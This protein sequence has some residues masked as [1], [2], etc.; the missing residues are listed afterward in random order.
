MDARNLLSVLQTIAEVEDVDQVRLTRRQQNYS[1]FLDLYQRVGYAPEETQARLVW[2]KRTAKTWRI[3]DEGVLPGTCAGGLGPDG[4]IVSGWGTLPISPSVVYGH[5]VC[6]ERTLWGVCT[7]YLLGLYSID[8]A[9]RI[10]GISHWAGSYPNHSGFTG[11]FQRPHFDIPGQIMVDVVKC[12]PR[13]SEVEGPGTE[14]PEPFQETDLDTLSETHRGVFHLL[15]STHPMMAKVHKG[16]TFTVRSKCGKVDAVLLVFDAIPELTAANVLSRV[17]AFP[18]THVVDI[19]GLAKLLQNSSM[20]HH[21]VL[22]LVM[23]NG[24]KSNSL[25]SATLIPSFW[26]FCP[27]ESFKLLKMS[28]ASAFEPTIAK[29]SSVD[30]G[31]VAMALTR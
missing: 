25:D 21:K 12:L 15:R 29:Y 22:H 31:A 10:D 13:A 9:N 3:L 1:Q 17:W 28:L 24:C 7:L 30:I 18:G 16:S 8:W 27:R 23:P 19:L 6:M 14:N 2:E 4:V 11:R 26:A 5:S 20:N